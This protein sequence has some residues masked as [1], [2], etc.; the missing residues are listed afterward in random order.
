[1]FSVS[2]GAGG[3]ISSTT[4]NITVTP[5]ND[6]PTVATNAGLIVNGCASRTI[7]NTKLLVSDPDNTAS[8]LTYSLTV[9][10]TD[11]T[12]AKNSTTLAVNDTFS[13]ADINNSLISYTHD[14][15][16][17][18][19]DSFT[20]TVSDGSGGTLSATTFNITVTPV[21]DTPTIS[22]NRTLILN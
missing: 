19:S 3:S 4:F 13:Q 15:G 14:G 1:T 9:V 17:T 22:V 18:T 7:G 20:F 8:Q 11:G 6:S 5:V 10:P 2:D 12:L 16:E 21:N